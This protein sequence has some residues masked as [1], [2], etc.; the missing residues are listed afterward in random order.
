MGKN[1][2]NCGME[3]RDEE[4]FCC[5]CGEKLDSTPF[6]PSVPI[7]KDP[8]L[9]HPPGSPPNYDLP[10]EHEPFVNPHPM[11]KKTKKLYI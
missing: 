4:K 3:C 11:K 5:N 7:M 10:D 8:P 9:L 2:R 6:N 1:C